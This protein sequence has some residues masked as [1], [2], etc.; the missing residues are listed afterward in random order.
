MQPKTTRH[1]K[2][3]DYMTQGREK[4]QK[5]LTKS[6]GIGVS[7]QEL[8]S[9]CDEFVNKCKVRYIVIMGDVIENFR[10]DLETAKWK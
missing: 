5:R 10:R 3:T 9:N 6:P 8:L 7:R 4:N 1:E 2:K